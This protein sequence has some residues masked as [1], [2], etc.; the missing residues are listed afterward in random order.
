MEDGQ[1]RAF[2]IACWS[3]LLN[4]AYALF[5]GVLGVKERSWWF[6]TLAV[7][8][9]VLAVM[10]FHAVNCGLREEGKRSQAH[11]ALACGLWLSFLAVVL[12]GMTYLMIHGQREAEEDFVVMIAIA[13]FTFWKAVTAVVRIVQA[14]K[15][16]QLLLITLR[17]IGCADA[18]ASMLTLE[19]MMVST[20]QQSYD[21]FAR[22]MDTAVGAGAFAVIFALGASLVILGIREGKK[23]K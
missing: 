6:F 1:Y 14:G 2:V 20:V 8:Y 15:K 9:A 3:L 5:H 4:L 17:N 12:S 19:H 10:R 11:T 18:A 23:E 16:K 21:G 13:A 7:Y 22:A